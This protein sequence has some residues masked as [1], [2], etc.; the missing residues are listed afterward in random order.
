MDEK[1][2]CGRGMRLK[3]N[4]SWVGI[5]LLSDAIYYI[6][7]FFP[8]YAPADKSWLHISW[9]I[10]VVFMLTF[11]ARQIIYFAITPRVHGKKYLVVDSLLLA[12]LLAKTVIP[13]LNIMSFLFGIIIFGIFSGFTFWPGI[14]LLGERPLNKYWK[15]RAALLLLFA[16]I[17]FA[18]AVLNMRPAYLWACTTEGITFIGLSLLIRLVT[19][20]FWHVA[21][22]E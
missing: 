10:P 17:L 8:S 9:N 16:A 15:V 22:S 6:L 21:R 14:L 12:A 2:L 3:R 11:V 4:Y 13:D 1:E 18:D 19:V 5:G 7:V 20:W